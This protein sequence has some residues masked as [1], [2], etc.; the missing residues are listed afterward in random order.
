M[1]KRLTYGSLPRSSSSF[2]TPM[3][4][5]LHYVRTDGIIRDEEGS[6]H[7]DLASARAEAIDAAR[8]IMAAA[9]RRGWDVSS[10]ALEITDGAQ[11]MLERVPFASA[12]R[13]GVQAEGL[14]ALHDQR[15]TL[16]SDR[17]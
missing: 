8:E 10:E 11:Q 15:A 4:Y 9:I 5:Y 16:R 6:E 1:M 17:S 13:P 3:R 12:V 14:A 2:E 7:P